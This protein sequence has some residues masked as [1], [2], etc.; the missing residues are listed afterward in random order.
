VHVISDQDIYDDKVI[1]NYLTANNL[2]G[3]TKDPLG[4][5]YKII[6]PGT[7]PI[8]EISEFSS[9]TTTYT[10]Y[11]L[12]GIGFDTASETTATTLTPYT[13]IPGVEDAL[14]KHAVTGTSISIFIPSSIGYGGNVQNTIPSNSVLRFEFQITGVTQP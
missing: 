14:E 2:T 3:Y 1:N 10:G 12:N 4:Y 8:E 13:L 9:V 5:Y 7:G 11:L 6:T